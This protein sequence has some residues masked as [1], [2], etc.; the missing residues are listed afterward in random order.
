MT[1]DLST[2]TSAADKW[3]DMAAEFKK[4]EDAYKRDVHKISL[5]ETWR[6]F[7]ATAANGRF[8]ATLREYQAA[9][10]EAKALAAVLR[11]AHTQFTDLRGRLKSVRADAIAD[12]MLVSEQGNVAYDYDKLSDGALKASRNDPDF[13][14]TVRAKESE[15]HQ[16][17]AGAVKAINDADEGVKIA[18]EAVV[19]DSNPMDG[20]GFNGQADAKKDIEEY[21][22]DN[23]ADIATRIN[24]GENVSAADRAELQRAF[25]DNTGNKDFT[26]T[27]LN[28]LGADDTLK[29]TNKLNDLAYFDDKGRKQ[30]YLGLQK[31]LAATLATATKDTD[32]KFYKD[33]RAELKKAGVEQYDLKAV[34]EKFEGRKGGDQ[35]IR[36]YQ[37]LV[38]LM[39]NGEG[40]SPQFL[41]DITDDMLDAEEKD[42]NLWD[43]RGSFG[44][45]ETAW[46][47]HDPVDGALGIMS[48]DPA[49]ATAFLD[50]GE[51]GKDAEHR[52]NDRLERLLDRETDF[53]D[54]YDWGVA[55]EHKLGDSMD[56]DLP[57]SKQGLA[58]AIEA[59][60]TGREPGA[61]GAEF[62][63][64]S[65]A[66]A[67][68]HAGH[69]HAPRSGR[70]GRHGP[71]EPE[72]S[73]RPRS[74]RLHGRH[75]LDSE[76]H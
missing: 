27:F 69:H 2:L 64:H 67:P 21:E 15:W 47:A 41:S 29:F 38:T 6:G 52:G 70:Q 19:I 59:A 54:R 62:G 18:L 72:G 68:C 25:R 40:Y 76:R 51:G 20:I 13:E 48:K 58:A 24:S 12:G 33:F 36:G 34:T 17:I 35:E 75:P 44:N 61:E 3:D 26:Q 7:A 23:A 45:K 43:L 1:T 4:L 73:P 9:Q 37:A 22:A 31:G 46:F 74:G 30:E 10:K 16:A 55:A 57:T 53:V 8:D 28:S 56:G 66:E 50:P 49:A 5:G 32:S 60:S 39:Q 63:R 11:E 65:A 71:R 42:P 14:P